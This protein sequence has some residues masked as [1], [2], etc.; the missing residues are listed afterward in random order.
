MSDDLP[1][2]NE[3]GEWVLTVT[4]NNNGVSVDK[5]FSSRQR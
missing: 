2:G 4:N 5:T 3:Q 1:G